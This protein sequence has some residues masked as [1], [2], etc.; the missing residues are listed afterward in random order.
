MYTKLS[1]IYE[2]AGHVMKTRRQG[3]RGERQ[4]RARHRPFPR[5]RRHGGGDGGRTTFEAALLLG[6]VEDATV[7]VPQ[8]KEQRSSLY[9]KTLPLSMTFFVNRESHR[10]CE[11][12]DF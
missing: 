12:A 1:T 5:S 3:C 8:E 4:H 11:R 6:I 2:Q 7:L 10:T 9:P